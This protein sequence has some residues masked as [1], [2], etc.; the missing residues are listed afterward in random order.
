MNFLEGFLTRRVQKQIPFVLG[1]STSYSDWIRKHPEGSQQ[2]ILYLIESESFD[3]FKIGIT[4]QS[5]KTDR[6]E[7]H[8]KEG[9]TLVQTWVLDGPVVAEAIE[10]TVLDWWR[11]GLKTKS[12]VTSVAMPQGGFTETISRQKVE[13]AEIL[14]FVEQ[15]C[16]KKYTRPV[17]E[18]NISE[19]NIGVR[20]VIIAKVTHA[21]LGMHHTKT[22]KGK[23]QGSWVYRYLVS[24]GFDS[25]V[26]E[27]HLGRKSPTKAGDHK[28]LPLVG[29]SIILEGRPHLVFGS[30]Y[31]FGFIDPYVKLEPAS[32]QIEQSKDGRCGNDK[33]HRYTQSTSNDKSPIWKCHDCGRETTSFFTGISCGV[34]NRGEIK[35][36][37]GSVKTYGRRTYSAVRTAKCS[38]CRQ[39]LPWHLIFFNNF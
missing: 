28:K 12:S 33:N 39:K 4:K 9:W 24:D 5:S 16:L 35:L 37:C 6:V 13:V 32:I 31:E 25:A 26:V 8:L 22:F 23:Q 29:S 21:K 17:I 38:R 19:L 36:W 2:G 10:Q 1:S 18:T 34:C 20:S 14:K 3:S 27:S 7:E 15:Q 11:H 30:D